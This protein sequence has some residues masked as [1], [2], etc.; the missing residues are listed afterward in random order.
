VIEPP[1]VAGVLDELVGQALVVLDN[2]TGKTDRRSDFLSLMDL[3][4]RGKR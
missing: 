3:M 4:T 2:V 1:T